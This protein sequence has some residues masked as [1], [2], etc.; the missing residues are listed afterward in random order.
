MTTIFEADHDGCTVADTWTTILDSG[1][2]L[3]SNG[4][5]ALNS[6]ICGVEAAFTAANGK[7]MFKT[8][9]PP[10]TNQTRLRAY[11]DPNSVSGTNVT[12]IFSVQ[13]NNPSPPSEMY[14]IRMNL[15]SGGNYKLQGLFRDDGNPFSTIVF[16]DEPGGQPAVP[17]S[18]EPH[19]LEIRIVRET[20]DGNNDGQVAFYMDGVQ[21]Y[22]A[23]NHQNY[24]AFA[25]IVRYTVVWTDST[26]PTG[27]MY[28][29]EFIL[30]DAADADL[31]CT[32]APATRVGPVFGD[33]YA[34]SAM[35]I[36]E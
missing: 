26:T 16:G 12:S 21:L 11:F 30:D 7:T 8:F 1:S 22:S 9:T 19:C 36:K 15:D 33:G 28:G 35:G 2:Q 29:D 32:V 4:A 17:V 25:N 6:S 13:L 5:S 14:M 20:A 3:S 31:G 10:G 18:D 27:T 34:L 24:N 23:T